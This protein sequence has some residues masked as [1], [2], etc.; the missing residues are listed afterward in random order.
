MIGT[1]FIAVGLSRVLAYHSTENNL[2]GF[3][4]KH[5]LLTFCRCCMTILIHFNV[6]EVLS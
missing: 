3:R 2:L 4:V 6:L 5:T 1:A